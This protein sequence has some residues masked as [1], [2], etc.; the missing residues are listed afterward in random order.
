MFTKII[1]A[2]IKKKYHILFLLTIISILVWIP[3]ISRGFEGNLKVN[4]FDVGQGDAIFLDFFDGNQIL[5][6]GGPDNAIMGRLGN[7]VP[8]YDRHIDMIILTHPHKDHVFGLIEVLK[9]YE[10]GKVVLP[11]IDF[12][13]AFY[14]EFLNTIKAK[15]IPIEYVSDGDIIKIGDFAEFDFLSPEPAEGLQKSFSTGS[16]SFGVSG[17]DLNDISLVAKFIYGD[18]AILFTGDA[19]VDIENKILEKGY[20]IRSDILKVGHHGSK[21][22]TSEE[23]LEEVSPIYSVIQVGQKNR[24]GHPTEQTLSRLKEYSSQILRNDVNGDVVFESDGNLIFLKK[25]GIFTTN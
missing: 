10:V 8:F 22:S 4:F 25:S 15:N 2:G 14:G 23:F 19:G 3:V 12:D 18:T 21:Y 9:R 16:E 7:A 24:Y 1:N 11:K 6:D 5:I 20:N 13:S 17:Q